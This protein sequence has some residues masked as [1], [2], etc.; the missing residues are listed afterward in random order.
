[1][2]LYGFL[3]NYLSKQYAHLIILK[4]VER[5]CHCIDYLEFKQW[6]PVF[7]EF[8]WWTPILKDISLDDWTLQKKLKNPIYYSTSNPIKF[9]IAKPLLKTVLRWL[10][11]HCYFYC[12]ENQM[13]SPSR[14]KIQIFDLEGLRD[15]ESK[16][17]FLAKVEESIK[18]WNFLKQ[19]FF[20]FMILRKE[21]SI[22]L[23]HWVL[24][25]YFFSLH[26]IN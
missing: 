8:E 10:R 7:S 17:I 12:K 9:H 21:I 23:R 25:A 4:K 15:V 20:H 6:D 19:F 18:I 24:L 1:M 11:G 26:K 2:H 14:P 22:I 3:V 16:K 5:V 13:R